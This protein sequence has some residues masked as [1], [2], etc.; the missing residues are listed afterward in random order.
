MFA[1]SIDDHLKWTAYCGAFCSLSPVFEI[2]SSII[3]GV[4]SA[5][6]HTAKN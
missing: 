6:S 2:P 3:D 1:L 4:E 5:P